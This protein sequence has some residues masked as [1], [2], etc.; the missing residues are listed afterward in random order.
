MKLHKDS[1]Q[2][3]HQGSKWNHALIVPRDML[4]SVLDKKTPPIFLQL[5]L[6]SLIGYW[7]I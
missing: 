5:M 7:V 2:Y 1:D 4:W 3:A 6:S